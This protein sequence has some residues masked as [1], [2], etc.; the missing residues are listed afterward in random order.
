MEQQP[1]APISEL[2]SGLFYAITDDEYNPLG[3]D[4]VISSFKGKTK[5]ETVRAPKTSQPETSSGHPNRC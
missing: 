5:L 3:L 4:N 2:V 1:A